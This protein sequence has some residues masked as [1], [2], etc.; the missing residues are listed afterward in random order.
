MPPGR[1]S[2]LSHTHSHNKAVSLPGGPRVD[3]LAVGYHLDMHYDALIF[4]LDGTLWDAAEASTLGWN[5]ALEELGLPQRVAIDDIRSVSGKPFALCVEIL[6]P[7]LHPAP[8]E[9]VEALE[10]G[11]RVGIETMAGE[12]YEGVPEGLSRLAEEFPLFIVSNCPEWYL[13]EFLRFSGMGRHL[14]GS[15]C[16]GCSG[17]SKP[18]MLAAMARRFGLARPVYVGDTDGDR[19]AA[20]EAGM[21][22]VFVSYGFGTVGEVAV[23]LET[24]PALVDYFLPVD[25][26]RADPQV[27][28]GR[29]AQTSGRMDSGRRRS[30]GSR[31]LS[32]RR[33]YNMPLQGFGLPLSP[34]GRASLTPV[35]PWHYAGDL[36]VVDFAAAPA[37]VE[38]VLP[39]ELEPDPA[40]PGGCTGFFVAWQYA[41]ET[42]EEFLDP[43]RSQYNEFILLVNA[44]YRD[45]AVS[46]C[47]YIYVDSDMSMARGWIQGWPKKLGEIHITRAFPLASKAAPRVEPGAKFGGTLTAKG[48]RLAEAVIELEGV[49]ADPVYFG[50][51]PVVN[52]R[53]FPQLAG[54]GKAKP[55]V[56][57]LVRSILS[58]VERTEI[59]EGSADLT[60][61]SAPD[62]E[63]DAFEPVETRRGYRY[64]MSM[65]IDDLEVL[66]VLEDV[67][68][69]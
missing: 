69:R 50:K 22:F 67:R 14:S 18:A 53:Y 12:L 45:E 35:P 47:P 40:D 55:P 39:G 64:S 13:E 7:E 9:L 44:R 27:S 62:N 60:F 29:G 34:E 56:C 52:L 1:L 11:E 31:W 48:R 43:V 54:G 17:M 23:R 10:A 37:A 26:T 15:D 5:R 36:L 19:A 4:D 21:D 42:G 33:R 20:E 6:L 38:A 65:R 57:E 28:R 2:R 61:F 16:H 8:P 66:Q 59:W 41:S 58:G 30:R 46:V 63:L 32:S 24:F 3:R 25:R 68:G 49:S 51:R